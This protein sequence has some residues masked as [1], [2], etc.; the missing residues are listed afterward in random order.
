MS[1]SKY[2]FVFA[3]TLLI[4]HAGF[5]DAADKKQAAKSANPAIKTSVADPV[6]AMEKITTKFAAFFKS[7]RKLLRKESY[8]NA[9]LYFIVEISASGFAFDVRKTDSLVSPY[10][11]YVNL[12]VDSRSNGSCGNVAGYN[13]MVGW[14][15][16]DD[17]TQAKD[18]EECFKYDIS[19]RPD[20][21][22][23]RI[24][25]SYQHDTWVLKRTTRVKY[26]VDEFPISTVLGVASDPSRN[27]TDLDVKTF[28][29]AWQILTTP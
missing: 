1:L 29:Q 27:E 25:F 26:S 22:E 17:A 8:K 14:R 5:S 12:S 28:N 15:L 16:L 20:P 6:K 4:T 9:P 2:P 3:A 18:R 21:R 13:E 19:G 10:V 23:V 24:D 7:P 11:G